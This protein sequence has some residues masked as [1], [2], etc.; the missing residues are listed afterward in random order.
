MASAIQTRPPVAVPYLHRLLEFAEP[1][2]TDLALDISHG[3]GPLPEALP[4]LVAHVAACDIDVRPAKAPSNGRM[5]TVQFSPTQ[6]RA[7]SRADPHHLP[8][9]DRSFSLVTARFALYRSG[10]TPR[11]LREMIR[12][13][14]PDGRIVIADLIRPDLAAGPDRD[15]VER[16][17][18][19][20]H[21]PTPSL[22]RLMHLV[23][24]SG[25]DVRRLDAFAVERPVEP[26]LGPLAKSP[27]GRHITDMLVDEVDGGPKTGARPR[28]IGGEL[29]FTQNWIHLA[30]TP[31]R[32]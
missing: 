13:C 12:V 28:I 31:R 3:P 21:P 25:A 9:R 27:T 32:P 6:E 7:Q 20:H 16:L 30:A 22:S 14:R 2:P 18:D 15:H 5:P 1:T 17:R 10:D 19:P 8:Y 4:P 23:T 29:W 11:A 26:W 24:E